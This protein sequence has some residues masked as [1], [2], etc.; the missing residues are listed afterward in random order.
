ML[1]ASEEGRHLPPMQ[2]F[3]GGVVTSTLIQAQLLQGIVWRSIV[4]RNP[5]CRGYTQLVLCCIQFSFKAL[6]TGYCEHKTRCN[7]RMYL[8]ESG[9][10]KC[11]GDP[12]MS[13]PL[14][15]SQQHL[16]VGRYTPSLEMNSLPTAPP[17]W[18]INQYMY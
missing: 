5:V 3:R 7:R 10:V 2:T 13:T 8:R 15:H 18:K 14:L 9:S 16:D 12:P 6:S 17:T 11:S 1:P 4:N